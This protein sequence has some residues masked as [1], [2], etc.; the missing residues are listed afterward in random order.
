MCVRVHCTL[1]TVHLC[2]TQIVVHVY[3]FY[4]HV[5]VS[6]QR[7]KHMCLGVYRFHT[8]VYITFH[9]CILLTHTCVYYFTPMYITYVQLCIKH[10]YM[11]ITYNLWVH[12]WRHVTLI[13]K[14]GRI[15]KPANLGIRKEQHERTVM[16]KM[17]LMR[18]MM[19]MMLLVMRM[20]LM[21]I[22]TMLT[23]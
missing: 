12:T 13:I 21:M 18:V 11:Y 23:I 22:M 2:N 4:T 5:H 14:L 16:M 10:V 19:M 1:Y 17:I 3:N 8:P 6:T 9:L 20:L 7:F 15:F